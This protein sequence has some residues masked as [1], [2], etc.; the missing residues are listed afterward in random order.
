MVDNSRGWCKRLQFVA[1]FCSLHSIS[2]C[3][4]R[5]RLGGLVVAY[6][7]GIAPQRPILSTPYSVSLPTP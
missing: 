1:G 7:F 4:N 2:V 3:G 5:A 6:G